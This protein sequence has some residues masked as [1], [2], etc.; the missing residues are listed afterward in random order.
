MTLLIKI[1][2]VDLHF[3]GITQKLINQPK[4]PMALVIKQTRNS[5]HTEI[6]VYCQALDIAPGTVNR[7]LGHVLN[8]IDVHCQVSLL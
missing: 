4:L 2:R 7:S 3:S 1:I 6:A 5:Q 8:I